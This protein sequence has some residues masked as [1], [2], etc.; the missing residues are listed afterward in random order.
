MRNKLGVMFTL[1]SIVGLF[2]CDRLIDE[3]GDFDIGPHANGPGGEAQDLS[4]PYLSCAPLEVQPEDASEVPPI[5]PACHGGC[6]GFQEND[7]TTYGFCIVRCEDS[8]DCLAWDP[9]GS[10]ASCVGSRCTWECDDDH[11]CPSGLECVGRGDPLPGDSSDAG[12]CY[13]PG[14]Q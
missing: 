14:A 2:G 9:G 3:S 12:E 11:L 13:A 4:H 8:S 10:V 1:T 6:G 7:E 5:D